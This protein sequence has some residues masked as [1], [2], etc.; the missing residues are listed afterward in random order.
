VLLILVLVVIA[1]AGV[2]SNLAAILSSVL[3]RLQGPYQSLDFSN[4]VPVGVV[5]Y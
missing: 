4:F 1:L 5:R 3:D 2:N